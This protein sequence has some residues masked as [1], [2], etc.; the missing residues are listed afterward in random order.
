MPGDLYTYADTTDAA[1]KLRL[2]GEALPLSLDNGYAT[3]RRAWRKGDVVELD[4]PM[5]IRRV[6]ANTRVAAD[7][8]RVALQRGPIV[9]A[10]EWVDSP[11]RHV[12]NIL[13][14]DDKPL[15]AEW[16]PN[17]LK[18]VEAI[19]GKV[20]AYRYDASRRLDRK[21]E[22]F[23]AIPYYAWANRGAG[24]MEVWIA[25]RE[26]AVHPTPYPSIASQAKVTSSGPTMAENGVRE[27]KLVA[28]QEEPTSSAIQFVLRLASEARDGASG[29]NTTSRIRPRCRRWMCT[30]SSRAETSPSRCPRAGVCCTNKAASGN[31]WKQR[32]RTE[33]LPTGTITCR[34][35]R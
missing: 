26:S 22:T 23:V 34:S 21:E 3:I 7:R 33:S 8:D 1:P 15:K 4:L 28:D 27:P 16:K 30:G 19:E 9:Y 29:F 2:N 17:L 31:R 13:L 18:G 35:V 14:R 12:R 25:E 20:T 24:Q 5:A 6:K 10:A 11:D 32:T